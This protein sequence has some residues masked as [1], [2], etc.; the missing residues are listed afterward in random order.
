MVWSLDVVR[1]ARTFLYPG[2][3]RETL[4]GLAPGGIDACVTDP[5]YHLTQPG[6]TKG[7]M[8]KVWDGGDISY[9]PETW[10]EVLRVLKPG[11]HLLCF[12]GTRTFHRI[13]V[14]IEDAGFEIR[15]TVMWIYGTGFPKSHN[16]GNGRGTA[17]CRHGNRSSSPASH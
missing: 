5:P 16:A 3:C 6:G 10:R 12:G 4:L 14:A 1:K 13:A 15:D 17:R 8:G 2:D 11:G 7:F 9:R